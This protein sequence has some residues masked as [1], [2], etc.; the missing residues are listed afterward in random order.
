MVLHGLAIGFDLIIY[1][2]II[3]WKHLQRHYYLVG[4]SLDWDS[5]STDF[6]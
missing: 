1:F 6:V 2:L 4:S 3:A 5:M